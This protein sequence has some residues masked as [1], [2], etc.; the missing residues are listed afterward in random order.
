MIALMIFAASKSK[1]TIK[2]VF[3]EV[4]SEEQFHL[5]RTYA[6]ILSTKKDS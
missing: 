3:I 1:F 4:L 5:S 6:T 2:K